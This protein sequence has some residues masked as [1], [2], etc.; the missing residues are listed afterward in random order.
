MITASP[1]GRSLIASR[2]C[3]DWSF[4]A[5]ASAWHATGRAAHT[6]RCEYDQIRRQIQDA[7]VV[8]VGETDVKRDGE[9]AWIRTFRTAGYTLYAVRGSWTCRSARERHGPELM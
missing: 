9:Q 5:G 8:H 7:D 1:T 2:N 6:G 3:T 4:R